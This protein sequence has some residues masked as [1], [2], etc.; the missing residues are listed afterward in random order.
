MEPILHTSTHYTQALR[1]GLHGS[2]L[3]GPFAEVCLSGGHTQ[4]EG[5]L[6]GG[7][8]TLLSWALQCHADAHG[9][10]TSSQREKPTS[11]LMVELFLC[12]KKHFI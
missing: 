8:A 10:L 9:N 7:Y 5:R 3:A 1:R 6:R 11:A 2:L 12:I 4:L